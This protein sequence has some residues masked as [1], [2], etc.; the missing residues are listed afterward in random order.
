[1]LCVEGVDVTNLPG[2]M[3]LARGSNPEDWKVREGVPELD[4]DWLSI[5]GE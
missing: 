5:D 4:N 1:M 3:G 2:M